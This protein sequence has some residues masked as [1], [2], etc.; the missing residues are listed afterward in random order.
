MSGMQFSHSY[1]GLHV[2][3]K[4]LIERLLPGGGNKRTTHAG[5]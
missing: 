1:I 4:A 5:T 3:N 2:V